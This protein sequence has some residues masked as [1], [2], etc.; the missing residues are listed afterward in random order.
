MTFTFLY[1]CLCHDSK[2]SSDR[3]SLRVVDLD[4]TDPEEDKDRQGGETSSGQ[5]GRHW[6][7]PAEHSRVRGHLTC[8]ATN[9]AHQHN[10]E[11]HVESWVVNVEACHLHDVSLEIWPA[12]AAEDKEGL[13]RHEDWRTEDGEVEVSQEDVEVTRAGAEEEANTETDEANYCWKQENI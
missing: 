6:E 10:D 8:H 13:E 3:L 12:V 9:Q 2:F 5:G 11:E 7:H 1:V 4:Q